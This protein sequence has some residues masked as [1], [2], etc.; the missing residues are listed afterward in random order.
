MSASSATPKPAIMPLL[1]IRVFLSSPIDLHEGGYR[2]AVK[3]LITHLNHVPYYENR[4]KFIEY[5]Y[6]D[7]VP[8]ELGVAPQRAVDHYTLR[9]EAADIV[10]CLFWKRLG[11]PTEGLLDPTTH[12]PYPSGAV[13]ELLTAYRYLEQELKRGG[14]G[15]TILLYRCTAPASFPALQ[16]PEQEQALDTF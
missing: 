10:I 14:V 3:A 5:A 6:E 11:S 9:P 7:R 13:Y 15:P 8:S 2:E 1:P 12:A 4:Y 16:T